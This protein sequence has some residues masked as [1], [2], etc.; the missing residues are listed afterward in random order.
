MVPEAA[1]TIC[2]SS[3]MVILLLFFSTIALMPTPLVR[4]RE[5]HSTNNGEAPSTEKDVQMLIE[6]VFTRKGYSNPD[7][8]TNDYPDPMP[9]EVATKS[10]GRKRR[11][12]PLQKIGPDFDPSKSYVIKHPNGTITY[13]PPKESPLNSS[14]TTSSSSSARA[15]QGSSSS[16]TEATTNRKAEASTSNG[17]A[18]RSR[19]CLSDNCS[20]DSIEFPDTMSTECSP[21]YPICTNVNNYPDQM[22]NNIVSR[23]KERFSEVFGNDVVVEDGDKLVQRFDGTDLDALCES[24][25]RLIHPKEGFTKDD[26]KIMIVNTQD[27]TQGVR[28]ET[29]RSGG[30]PC[31]SLSKVFAKTECRQ[32]YHY[33]T[34][35]AIDPKSNQPYKEKFRL[36]SCCKCFITRSFRRKRDVEG[37]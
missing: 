11:K 14:S 37:L 20:T 9:E 22:I 7:P 28:I 13:I 10:D 5:P 34:L 12:R 30:N 23:H 24:V 8:S 3:G 16:T 4:P 35:L 26:Q 15:T 36:P 6:E 19:R 17:V 18:Y 31:D 29:C 27:Y 33:R 21:T 2:L 25:E 1:W 32:L